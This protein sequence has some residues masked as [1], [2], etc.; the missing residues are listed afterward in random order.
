MRF[1]LTAIIALTYAQ[2]HAQNSADPQLIV[3]NYLKAMLAG[4][5]SSTIELMDDNIVDHHPTV[6]AAPTMGVTN[7]W[8]R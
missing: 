3:S 6:L 2:L 1:M 7:S 5:W 8:S 4:D